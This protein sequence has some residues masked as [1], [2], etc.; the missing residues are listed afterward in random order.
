MAAAILS[1]SEFDSVVRIKQRKEAPSKPAFKFFSCE[2]VCTIATAPHC[3]YI[4]IGFQS[5]IMHVYK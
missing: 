5:G 4:W 2:N 1:W 3:P